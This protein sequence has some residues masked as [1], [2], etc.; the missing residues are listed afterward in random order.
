VGWQVTDELSE[1][2]L[3]DIH[4]LLSAI[5][6]EAL[7]VTGLGSIPPEN[8]QIEKSESSPNQVILHWLLVG[9]KF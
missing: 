3:A 1:Y 4:P 7:A 2:S 5:A 9:R 6:I 8:F